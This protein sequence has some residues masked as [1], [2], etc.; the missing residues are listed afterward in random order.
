MERTRGSK[1]DFPARILSR[2][3]G[4]IQ[5][6][7]KRRGAKPEE[8]PYPEMFKAA[9]NLAQEFLLIRLMEL[10]W[11][12]EPGW[13]EEQATSSDLAAFYDRLLGF[14]NALGLEIFRPNLSKSLEL[15]PEEISGFVSEL[16]SAQYLP[17]KTPAELLGGL[18]EKIG[19][20]HP[21]QAAF[22]TPA[23]LVKLMADESFKALGWE[24]RLEDREFMILDPSFGSG[25]FL[26]GLMRKMISLEEDYYAHRPSGLFYPLVR[27]PDLSR[28]IEAELRIELLRK[29][30]FG[31]E[32]SPEG[33]LSAFRSLLPVVLSGKKI[34]E[35]PVGQ[36]AF[37]EQ[38]FPLGDFLIDQPLRQ[39]IGLFERA[40]LGEILT[41]SFSDERYP[42][43]QALP[44]GGFELVIGNPP[45]LS[46]KGRQALQPYTPDVIQWLLERFH[47][48]SY[49]PN[50]FEMFIRRGLELL[51]PDGVN[52]F[53]VPDRMAENLQFQPLRKFM[54]EQGEI[55]RLHFREPFPGVISD[56]LIYWLKKKPGGA[57]GKIKITDAQAEHAE[58]SARRFISKGGTIAKE[59]SE[60]VAALRE[61]IRH[62]AKAVISDYLNSGVGLIARPGTIHPEKL[63]RQEQELLKGE[64]VQ[65]WKVSGHYY[66]DFQPRN[67]IGGTVRFSKLTAPER[68]L[69]RKTGA[70]LMA[71]LDRSKRLV[72]QSA[73]FLVPKPDK[74]LKYELEYFLA[75]INSRLAN[76]YYR[77][78]LITNPASTPQLKKFHLD[79]LPVKRPDLKN[80]RER[81]LYHQIVDL[82]KNLSGASDPDERKK[83]EQ[84][85]DNLIFDLHHLDEK[86]RALILEKAG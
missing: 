45:W 69:V 36:L 38:N 54:I 62:E 60:E 55:L 14:N 46:L 11:M 33:R 66:F 26:L 84:K 9:F 32:L 43:R 39:Q 75:L 73:Y 10:N 3:Q 42:H 70:Q 83:L 71:A 24:G 22:F 74:K 19:F 63:D 35:L 27:L 50:L 58:I 37:L 12:L 48:D 56:T 65:T 20:R 28:T 44:R 47:A 6:L 29:H 67:L 85:L 15:A 64:N 21:E 16:Y 4:F 52:C 76:F 61:K 40:S 82:A 53:L 2:G 49:R 8:A 13:L 86:D 34:E 59:T 5:Q 31:L 30:L 51:K 79:Q 23:P 81:P 17:P 68:I 72:E 25:N 7:L 77:H 41:F 57:S 18:I 1:Y 78:A 80:P